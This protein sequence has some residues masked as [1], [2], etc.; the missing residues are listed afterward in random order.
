M[1]YIKKLAATQLWNAGGVEL[2]DFSRANENEE[3]RIEA[4]ATVASICYGKPPKDAKKL[5]ERLW[6]ESGGLPASAFE[7]VR[8]GDADPESTDIENSLRN[9]PGLETDESYSERMKAPLSILA[10]GHRS[11]VATFRLTIPIF[12]ARQ[13]MRHRSF[14]FQELSRRFVD[15][16][17][18]PFQFWMPPTEFTLTAFA[19]DEPYASLDAFYSAAVGVYEEMV[20]AG[21]RREIARGVL[22]Q[23]LYTTFWMQGNV[24]AWENYFTLRLDKRAQKEHRQL[25]AAML[26]LLGKFQPELWEAVRPNGITEQ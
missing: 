11:S 17:R 25:A 8:P 18:L 6:T 23:S 10:E 12:I 3:S 2:W 1:K 21:A 26:D 19:F 5:V 14:S 20:R 22:P 16:G 13:V 4:I 24:P 7:F 9:F 15:Q